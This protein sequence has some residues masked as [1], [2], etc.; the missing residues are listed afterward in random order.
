MLA[1]IREAR[2]RGA[3]RVVVATPT[4]SQQALERVAGEADA[5]FAANLRTTPWFAVAEAY[6]HWRDIPLEEAAALVRKAHD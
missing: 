1:A 2:A 4:A 3:A 6:T 5:V